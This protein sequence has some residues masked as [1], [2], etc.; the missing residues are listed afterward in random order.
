MVWVAGQQFE[1][2]STV[3]GPSEWVNS[4][5]FWTRVG[6]DGSTVYG[7]ERSGPKWTDP[8]IPKTELHTHTSEHI[9]FPYT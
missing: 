1:I 8:N 2:G 5:W 7:V 9:P 6:K 3:Y 4:S